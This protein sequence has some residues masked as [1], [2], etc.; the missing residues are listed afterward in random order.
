MNSFGAGVD[1][2]LILTLLSNPRKNNIMKKIIAQNCGNGSIPIA[3]GYVM[4][5]SAGPPV[6]TV[7]TGR[8]VT[9]KNYYFSNSMPFFPHEKNDVCLRDMNPKTEKTTNPANTLVPQFTI[10]TRIESLKNA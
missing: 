1:D 7:D 4:N 5:A 8:P 2:M 9:S 6:A 3:S 10:G